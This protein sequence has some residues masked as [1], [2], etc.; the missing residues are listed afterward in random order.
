MQYS[1]GACLLCGP[2]RLTFQRNHL[3]TKYV[4]CSSCD[5]RYTEG[6]QSLNWVKIMKTINDDPEG[7][8]DNGGWTFLE[9]ESDVRLLP[10]CLF[11]SLSQLFFLRQI[12][13]KRTEIVPSCFPLFRGKGRSANSLYYY[14]VGGVGWVGSFVLWC[15]L[16]S[17]FRTVSC[18]EIEV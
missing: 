6:V 18:I 13:K 12:K 14:N 16:I 5:I 17:R 8:F 4:L 3:Y 15:Q 2:G 11:C 7:F 1:A 10:V 9:P